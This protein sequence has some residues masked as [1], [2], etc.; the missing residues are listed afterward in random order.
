MSA[1]SEAIKAPATLDGWAILHRVFEVDWAA[2][3]RRNPIEKE[4]S[5][6]EA[7]DYL[8][9]SAPAEGGETACVSLL[10]HKGD[11]LILHVRKTLDELNAAELGFSQLSLAEVLKPT[12]SYVSIL[13]LGMYEMTVKLANEFLAAGL[14]RDSEE[15]NRRWTSAMDEQRER[16]KGRLYPGIPKH[17]YVCFYP[18][19]K[20]RG[21]QVN[22]YSL[23]VEKRQAMMRD[24]GLIGRKYGDRVTQII[25]GSIGF[26]DWEWGV[27]LFADE[28]NVFKEL[29]YEM[30]FD[31]ASAAYA[32]FGP[33][34]VGLQFPAAELT[35]LFQGKTPTWNR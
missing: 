19:N 10:G 9:K 11:L 16:V 2:W 20:R 14:S 24:H 26:D 18:M 7:T 33:F 15:W 1:L 3:N 13:E 31:E 25:T 4:K 23:P 32:E 35:T 6:S 28:P 17:R 22:W 29:I 8:K 21:E 27:Y 34:Y 12:T 5:L 30:R